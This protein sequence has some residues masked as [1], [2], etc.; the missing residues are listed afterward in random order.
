MTG[1]SPIERL[2]FAALSAHIRFCEAEYKDVL[3]PVDSAHLGRLLA[4]HHPL[5]LIVQP[6]AQL[7]GWRVDFMIYAWD[8]GRA[9]GRQQWRRLIVE[10]DG[11]DFHERTKEQAKKDRS[12]D[13]QAQLLGMTVLRFTGHELHSDP[14]GCARQ[15]SEWGTMGW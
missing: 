15:V 1:D 7:E 2:F 11:H 3:V 6:Q 10:C 14:L 8:F 13:R 4:E 5:A 12:R 9:T